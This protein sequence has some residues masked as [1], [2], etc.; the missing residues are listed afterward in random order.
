MFFDSKLPS[1]WW[2]QI[3]NT[4]FRTLWATLKFISFNRAYLMT[5]SEIIL[6][7]EFNDLSYNVIPSWF[8]SDANPYPNFI[9]Y[10]V[11]WN[12]FQF[13]IFSRRISIVAFVVSW[14]LFLRYPRKKK[15]VHQIRR[16]GK[17]CSWT[18]LWKFK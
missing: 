18:S 4:T 8:S 10:F 2:I 7:S 16:S 11:A 17:P 1:I 3:L 13:S 14:I 9:S 5:L 12:T 6:H 15:S